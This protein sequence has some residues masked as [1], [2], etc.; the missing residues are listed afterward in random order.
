MGVPGYQVSY[1]NYKKSAGKRVAHTIREY[2]ESGTEIEATIVELA[3]LTSPDETQFAVQQ[4]SAPLQTIPVS[5]ETVRRFAVNAPDITWPAI[6]SGSETGTLSLYVC[7]DRNGHVREIYELNSSNPGL[8]DVARDQ[9]MKWQFKPAVDQGVPVQ[10]ES[11][12]TFA[13]NAAVANPIPVVE[14]ADGRKLV[15][16]RVE[17]NFPQGFAPMGTPIIVTLGVR[18]NGECSGVVFITSDADHRA[19]VMK[20]ENLAMLASR[21][22]LALKQW[23]FRPYLQDGKATEFQMRVTF[24]VD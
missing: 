5:E 17:P 24:H 18:E 12:L 20:P 21:L 6:R 4:T 10:V 19:L 14:E 1:K 11:I 2:I 7:L 23:K 13:F 22:N 16:H 3:D 8:S 9:V 15:E